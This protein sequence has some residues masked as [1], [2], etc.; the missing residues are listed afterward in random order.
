MTKILMTTWDGAG[1]TPPLMSVASALVARGHEV[2]VLA[3]PVLR[4]DVEATGAEHV[5]WTRAPHRR[6]TDLD[7]HFVRDWEAG[8]EG[9]ACMRDNLAV[10]PASAFAADVREEIIRSNSEVVLTELLLFGPQVA[11]EA[12][13][14][15]Y[16]VLNPTINVIPSPGVPPFGQGLMPAETDADHERDR[17]AAE[18]GMQA[19]DEALP[20]LNAAR[21]EQGL[22]PLEHVLDQG[23][24]AAL[25]LVMT[26]S[27]FDFTGELPPTVKHVGPRL[28]DP[29]WVEDWTPPTGDD[30]LVLVALSSDFQGQGD[31]LRRIAAAL[32]EVPIRAVLTTGKGI[33][34]TEIPAGPQ[35]Q[36]VR[37]APHVEVL[38]KADA[39]VTHCGHGITI[40]A[41]AAGVPMVCLPM[42]RDQ[43]DI[44]ARVVHRGAG[45]RLDPASDPGEIAAATRRVLDEPDFREAAER[46]AAV[47]A[48]ETASDRAMAE[49]ETL[50]AERVMRATV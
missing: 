39:V 12:A 10:G 50:L 41:L 11:A 5:S 48:E 44:A 23:R 2:R 43:L 20:A 26:S 28:D 33:H 30:P 3:D 35:V 42:G 27:A 22:D 34:P 40:K 46:I 49:I 9:F 47:I 4:S 19:W 18:I 7:S 38:A 36:V 15:P 31:L 25:T 29:D 14:V 21:A 16:V 37:S 13:G 17:V 1:T 24:S 45:L 8:P 6:S 32:G